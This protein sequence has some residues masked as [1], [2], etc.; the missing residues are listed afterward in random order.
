MKERAVMPKYAVVKSV[1]SPTGS[2][3]NCTSCASANLVELSTEICIQLP[4]PNG[5]KEV[6]APVCASGKIVVCC[7]CGTLL[8]SLSPQILRLIKESAVKVKEGRVPGYLGKALD[9]VKPH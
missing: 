7:D 2:V 5:F 4:G 3:L 8:S 1:Q 9:R 6:K